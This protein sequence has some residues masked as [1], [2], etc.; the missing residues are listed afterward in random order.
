MADVSLRESIVRRQTEIQNT[1]I[2]ITL[3]H[4]Y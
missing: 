4:L 2:Y 1:Y 3:E